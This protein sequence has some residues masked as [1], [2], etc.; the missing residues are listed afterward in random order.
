MSEIVKI[1]LNME[2]NSIASSKLDYL[3]VKTA[4]TG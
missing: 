1:Y 4:H 2:H 3:I